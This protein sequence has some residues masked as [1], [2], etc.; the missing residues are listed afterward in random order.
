MHHSTS[1]N[2]T[3]KENKKKKNSKGQGN[4]PIL[5]SCCFIAIM[6]SL[7]RPF[8]GSG[9]IYFFNIKYICIFFLPVRH[10]QSKFSVESGRWRTEGELLRCKPLRPQLNHCQQIFTEHKI[11]QNT[12]HIFTVLHTQVKPHFR[13]LIFTIK[14]PCMN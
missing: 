6:Y 13:Q 12:D 4:F 8:K 11:T 1:E 14:K 7:P 9:I 2:L 3:Q 10:M 5:W